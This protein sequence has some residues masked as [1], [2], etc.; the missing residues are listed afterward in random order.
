MIVVEEFIQTTR[1]YKYYVLEGGIRCPCIKCEC[2][3]ILKDEEVKVHVYKKGFMPDYWIWT[4]HDEEVP[5]VYLGEH[6]RCLPSSSTVVPTFEMNQ[7]MYMQEMLNNALGQRDSFEQVNDNCLEESPNELTQRFYNLLGEANELVFEGVRESKLSVCI[8]LLAFK[9]NW[10]VP[11]QALDQ[12]AKLIL[13]LTP[14]NNPLP[15]NYYEA[16]KLV[17]KLGLESKKIDCCVND[18]M[19][20]YDNDNGKNDASLLNANIV[21]NHDTTQNIQNR[22]KKNQFH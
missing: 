19:F 7:A 11:N 10:N 12:I 20:F 14:P 5:S 21:G 2:T 22:G 6:E 3:R 9:S 1:Q 8:R 16:K 18:C 15:N 17:S 4:F 13:D